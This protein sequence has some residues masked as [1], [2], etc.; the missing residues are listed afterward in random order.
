MTVLP[1]LGPFIRDAR[2][3]GYSDETIK[4]AL[5]KKNWPK[6]HV[7]KEFRKLEPSDIVGDKVIV[8]IFLDQE[9]SKK[10]E[11][12]A[13]KNMLTLSEQIEDILRRSALNQKKSLPEDKVDD[14]LISV[15][16]RR[17]KK[18]GKKRKK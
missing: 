14:R 6:E 16:S 7:E 4:L 1:S 18:N 3:K 5:I 15:F 11:K 8:T 17:G 9:L 13:K 2:R 10:L 12:R